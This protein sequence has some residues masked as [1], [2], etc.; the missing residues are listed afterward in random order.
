VTADT[1]G[2][3]GAEGAGTAAPEAPAGPAASRDQA[4]RQRLLITLEQTEWN[5]SLT[6]A[7]LGI[8]RNTVYARLEK[9]GLWPDRPGK[10]AP[11][12]PGPVSTAVRPSP[13]DP[14]LHWERRSLT[15]LRADLTRTDRA[16]AWSQYS[17]VL[18]VIIAKVHSFGGR[19]EEL[20]PTGLVAAF[21]LEPV[22]DA[23]RRAA[24]AA[25]AIQKGAERTHESGD[26][27]PGI[28]IGLHVAPLL[29]GRVGPRIKIDAAAMQAERPVLHQLVQATE[30]GNTVASGAAAPF[31]ERRFE[32]ERLDATPSGQTAAYRLTG[33]ERRGLGL[34]GTVTR[35]V[36]R[37]NDLETLR[38]RMALAKRGHGQVVASIGEPGVGKSRLFWELTH[39][40]R[41][42]GWLVLEAGSVS[43]GKATPYLPAVDL[44]K[45]YFRIHDQDTRRDV[46]EKVTC[47]LLA[48]DR[49]LEPAL[50]ALLALLDVPVED[51]EWLELEPRAR[52]QRTLDAVKRVLLRESRAQPILLVF[53]DLHW[54]D[55]E[56]QA[57]L[58]T[59]VESLPAVR[60]LLL[61]NY[62]PE[63]AHAWGS[64]TYY[65]QLR[66]DP[67][68]AESAGA[69]LTGLLGNHPSVEA[70]KH[71]LVERTEGNP[72]FLDESVRSL[73]ESG[74][75]AGERG[76]HR[77]DRPI[78]A[79][80]VPPTVQAVLAARI[81][82]LPLPDEQLLQAAAAVGKD[83]PRPL[84]EA[85]AGLDAE[86]LSGGLARLQAGEF[87]YEAS[88]F[89]E[90]EY[91]FKHALTHE[92]AYGALLL[93]RR[94]DLHVRIL[95]TVERLHAGRLEEQVERCVHH[96]FLGEVWD[97]AA[98]YAQQAGIRAVDRSAYAPAIQYFGQALEA[99]ARLP[100]SRETLERRVETI[101]LRNSALFVLGQHEQLLAA[102]EQALPLAE[103][104]G[105]R[106]RLVFLT[107]GMG[108]ALWLSGEYARALPVSERALAIADEIGAQALRITTRLDVGLIRGSLGD[109]QGAVAPLSE[110][111]TLLV[112]D[113][114]WQR[115]DR[116]FHPAISLRTTLVGC[117]LELG[118]FARARTVAQ[119]AVDVAESLRHAGGLVLA[120][121]TA[122]RCSMGE[123]RFA[124][125]VPL[126][127]RALDL[128]CQAAIPYL[129]ANMAGRLGHAYAMSERV[130]EGLPIIEQ[131]VDRAP[132]AN[133]PVET[134]VQ[135][136]LA[137]A[138]VTAGRLDEA[139][140]AVE[141]TLALAR[142]R[143]ER[144]VEAHSLRLRGEIMWQ[145][146]P[147]ALEPAGTDLRDAL[148]LASERGMRPLV[149]HC[150]LG[151][152]K[153]YR[154]TDKREQAREPLT[155]ATTMYRE[156]GMTYWLQQAAVETAALQ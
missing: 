117:L 1:L 24:H 110:A 138:Y 37:E 70:L 6:A 65:S 143:S 26:G 125:A 83:V 72:L 21:G 40:H 95:G 151:L 30:P 154:R 57:L 45:G 15:L 78:A 34:W 49:A 97:R 99:L 35:F 103:K 139:A 101:S 135:L 137:S 156:M 93:E 47:K 104:L 62:R 20:T 13:P 111:L 74:A 112:G 155:T 61:V 12:S 85:I 76:A 133:R 140:T 129:E 71:L 89:P 18:D 53:E 28:T 69:L 14:G 120:F 102:Y 149:A 148:A 36:G 55:G 116:A 29:I 105:N 128:S 60:M 3:L 91:T 63:Y 86:A 100:D 150:H 152:G 17:R 127:E 145:R 38:S 82:R 141:T 136:Y 73:V 25:T 33:K 41:T 77:L 54:I 75:L 134:Q 90:L 94:R 42:D 59:L 118:E 126:L 121:S 4:M 51:P 109:Y 81:D 56:T 2:L 7:R 113:L 106:R 131:A 144:G 79:A 92:V 147:G 108:N 23:P 22:E 52:R 80:Q 39:S 132:R 67:L 119:D 48:L 66:L 9:F 84:L 87:L 31:L 10:A 114:A 8:A 64:R 68:P 44:L 96:A 88:L 130:G 115:L 16:D 5:I 46:Q 153:L 123:G 146:D 19:V 43:Y 142:Q 50:P 124:D 122:S 32:L 58:D 107:N 11:I 98:A 27:G